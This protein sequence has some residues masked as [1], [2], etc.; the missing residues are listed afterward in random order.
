M[1]AIDWITV[2]GF[3]SLKDIE[4]LRL[5]D[6]N[7][8]IGSNG[9]GKS[10]FI[11][12][13]SFLNFIRDGK[14]KEYVAT[15]GGASSILY[16]GLKETDSIKIHLSFSNERNQYKIELSYADGDLLKPTSELVYYWD[17][18]RYSHPYDTSLSSSH[19]EAGISVP[20]N[21]AVTSYVQ[22]HLQKWRVYHFHDTSRSSP[23]KQTC[24]VDDNRF[25][26]PDG[27]NL[28]SFLFLIR[29]KYPECFSLIRN[30]VKRVAPFFEDFSLV[31]SELNEGKVKLEWKHVGTDAYFSASSLSDGTLRFI[32]LST[33][34]LQPS[35]LRPSVILIDEPELG[36]HPYALGILAATIRSAGSGA[37]IIVSTQSALFLDYFEPK[38]VLVADRV[39]GATTFNR[40]NDERL[41]SWLEEYSLGQLWEKAE[42]GGRP[43]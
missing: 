18:S 4:K 39:D 17:K 37:Q 38:D 40:L 34:L 31:P 28:A 43:R 8:I 12:V 3:K 41:S 7:V 11:N 27:S 30:T 22:N 6:V 15:S 5:N 10:N 2:Q 29:Q 33:L 32:A 24:D 35:V 1:P 19:G 25:L 21:E 20:T 23:M 42:L 13:F 16:M 26:R 14:L 36:L 9:S